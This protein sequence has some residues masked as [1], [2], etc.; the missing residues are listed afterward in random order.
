M[1]TKKQGLIWFFTEIFQFIIFVMGSLML[2]WLYAPYSV[3]T[4][5]LISI[6]S[7][8][9]IYD[10]MKNFIYV[11]YILWKEYLSQQQKDNTTN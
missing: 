2:L 7:T 3:L 6:F 5:V 4:K 10:I 8:I 9:V 1:K 11:R